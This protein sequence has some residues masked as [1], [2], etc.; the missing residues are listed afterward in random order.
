MQK[1]C[2]AGLWAVGRVGG[3]QGGRVHASTA[4][5]CVFG[6]CVRGWNWLQCSVHLARRWSSVCTCSGGRMVEESVHVCWG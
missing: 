5:R 1:G 6:V 3:R 4:R 2:R